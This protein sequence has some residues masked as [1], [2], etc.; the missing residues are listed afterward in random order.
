[1]KI[2]GYLKKFISWEDFKKANIYFLPLRELSDFRS[3]CLKH[4]Y[5]I[6]EGAR[7]MFDAVYVKTSATDAGGYPKYK[8]NTKIDFYF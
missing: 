3:E 1:M 5:S 2:Q 7:R 6:E 8:L 4:G